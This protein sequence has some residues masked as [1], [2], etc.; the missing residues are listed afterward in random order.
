METFLM[1][2]F[3]V[4]YANFF[5]GQANYHICISNRCFLFVLLLLLKTNKQTDNTHLQNEPNQIKHFLSLSRN[6]RP[7][8]KESF[9]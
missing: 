7:F 8:P 5:P 2:A 3:H 1:S 9:I 6:Q 4:I